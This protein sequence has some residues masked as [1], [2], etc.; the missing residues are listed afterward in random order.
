MH[1]RSG[2]IFTNWIDGKHV[3][4]HAGF[5]HDPWT[6][7]Q[8]PLS[9]YRAAMAHHQAL[10]REGGGGSGQGAAAA[11]ARAM[12]VTAPD[13]ANPV[14]APLLAQGADTSNGSMPVLLSSSDSFAQDL[15]QLLCAQALALSDSSL[16]PMLLA[17]PNVQEVY[18]FSHTGCDTSSTCDQRR[19]GPAAPRRYWCIAGDGA[20]GVGK[21]WANDVAGRKEMLTYSVRPPVSV[22]VT[23]F[24][25]VAN[26]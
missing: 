10:K 7:G 8:P 2:E 9:F 24:G 25:C 5:Q 18:F 19:L 6:R 21:R 17:S 15:S 16:N 13:R 14:V 4:T 20:Y 11:R 1:I 12:V 3:H 22:N 23:K 26:R